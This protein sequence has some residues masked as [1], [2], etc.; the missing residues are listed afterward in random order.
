M[1]AAFPYVVSHEDGEVE[2]GMTLRDYFAGQA[3]A[4]LLSGTLSSG[5]DETPA[6]EQVR[7]D[8]ARK[9]YLYGAAMMSERELWEGSP[10]P[11]DSADGLTDRETVKE[12]LS[13]IM[14][15]CK[16]CGGWKDEYG[17]TPKGQATET[18][19]PCPGE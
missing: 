13:G 3:L 5:V 10:M 15:L 6:G 19:Q 12:A 18:P 7:A 14:K 11:L 9:A 8:K 16:T 1:K 4:G 17:C 2:E